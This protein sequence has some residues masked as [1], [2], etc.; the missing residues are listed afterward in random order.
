M[1]SA[2]P[3]CGAAVLALTS[4]ASLW[5]L[6]VSPG[7]AQQAPGAPEGFHAPAPRQALPND[8]LGSQALI[9]LTVLSA[10]GNRVGSIEQVE[11]AP[12]GTPR[13]I[14]I[15]TGGFLGFGTRL[16]AVDGGKFTKI[17]NVVRVHLTTDEVGK[18]ADFK[19]GT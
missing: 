14:Y 18:L 7:G 6:S 9:G 3:R 11:A 15:R 19:G 17:G 10:D 8:A 4:W 5:G 1:R 13:A 2:K 12:D 16:V